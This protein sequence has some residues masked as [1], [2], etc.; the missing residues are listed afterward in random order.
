[1]LFY[2][3]IDFSFRVK[4]GVY[5]Q[6]QNIN[7]AVLSKYY[8]SLSLW[9]QGRINMLLI[10]LQALQTGTG[11]EATVQGTL[12]PPAMPTL[13]LPPLHRKSTDI[14]SPPPAGATSPL[15]RGTRCR[16]HARQ[17]NVLPLHEGQAVSTLPPGNHK[18]FNKRQ[19]CVTRPTR[20]PG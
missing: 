4:Q 3:G 8:T 5:V 18:D 14:W 12:W 20:S 7:A 17:E 2:C 16:G 15:Q 6:T 11:P 13:A 10:D 1:M 19:P 9:D